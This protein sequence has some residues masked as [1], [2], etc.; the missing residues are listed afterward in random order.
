MLSADP[1]KGASGLAS[2]FNCSAID[3][4]A[5]ET[6]GFSGAKLGTGGAPAKRSYLTDPLRLI[7][8]VGNV[9][10]LPYSIKMSGETKLSHDM[11]AHADYLRFALSVEG[12]IPNPPTNRPDEFA[13]S[14]YDAANWDNLQAAALATSAFPLAFR[15]RLLRRPLAV[16]GY[17][18]AVVPGESA[19]AE[20]VQLLPRWDVPA[21]R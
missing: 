4:Q 18:V 3:A 12:G 21:R 1:E 9:T 10:G 19:D 15:S 11:V 5:A 14:S 20:V 7:M 17:R 8:M 6:I 2:V 13:L 16:S